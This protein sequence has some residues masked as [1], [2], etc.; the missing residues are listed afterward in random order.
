MMKLMMVMRMVLMITG[1]KR[2]T[3]RENKRIIYSSVSFRLPHLQPL[4]ISRPKASLTFVPFS[5]LIHFIFNHL[6]PFP[7]PLGHSAPIAHLHGQPHPWRSVL[8]RLSHFQNASIPNSS[9]SKLFSFQIIFST[10]TDGFMNDNACAGGAA[11]QHVG[12]SRYVPHKSLICPFQGAARAGSGA[13][14]WLT[15]TLKGGVKLPVFPT[16]AE[17]QHRGSHDLEN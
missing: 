11:R 3:S 17:P 15:P 12:E 1:K 7:F 5:T 10:K 14:V 13:A 8:S 6:T 9:Y 4:P 2:Q 16:H